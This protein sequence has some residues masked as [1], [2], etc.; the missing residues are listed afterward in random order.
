MSQEEKQSMVITLSP[1]FNVDTHGAISFNLEQYKTTHKVYPD[2]S[3][4][5]VSTVSYQAWLATFN[6]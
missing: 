6:A 3:G 5:E 4:G 1:A 2:G